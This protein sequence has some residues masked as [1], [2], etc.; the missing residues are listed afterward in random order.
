MGL[1]FENLTLQIFPGL[2]NLIAFS[3][4]RY[5]AVFPF[6]QRFFVLHRTTTSIHAARTFNATLAGMLR[7]SMATLQR[8][9]GLGIFL[10]VIAVGYSV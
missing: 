3:L 10:M 5:M 7:E 4:G 1:T 2:Y 6:L 8:P 9:T